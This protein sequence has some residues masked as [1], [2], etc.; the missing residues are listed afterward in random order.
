MQNLQ[1]TKSS[2]ESDLK[3]YFTA[4][5]ELSKSDNQFPINLDE[6]WPLVYSGR[7]KAT[8]ALKENFFENEDFITMT[9]NGQGGQFAKIDY[10]LSLSCMEYFIARKVRPVFEVYRQVFHKTA[11]TP[12]LPQNYKQ[13]LQQLLASVEQN[14][15][16]QLE[17]NELQKDVKDKQQEIEQQRA[18]IVLQESELKQSAPKAEYYDNVLQSKNTYTST[19]VA[20]ELG[21]RHAEQLHRELQ[22]REILFHAC[23]Q[24]VLTAKYCQKDYTRTR[25]HTYVRNDGSQGTNTITVWTEAGRVFLHKV[26]NV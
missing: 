4:V 2:S 26:F 5:L 14:E 18:T 17:N 8:R 20:K 16:L 23:G 6:V 11:T 7:N 9:Q 12:T 3:R 21:M 22:R 13:A 15:K 25:T 19:V 10:F 1:L 24:W